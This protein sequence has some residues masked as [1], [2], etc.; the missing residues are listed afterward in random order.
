M[1]NLNDSIVEDTAVILCWVG[2]A[3]AHDPVDSRSVAMNEEKEI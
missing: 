2:Y 3:I 1:S